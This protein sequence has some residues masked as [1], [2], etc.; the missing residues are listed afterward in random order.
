M[1]KPDQPINQKGW[2]VNHRNFYLKKFKKEQLTKLN[3]SERKEIINVRAG[4]LKWKTV[5][6]KISKIKIWFFEKHELE[7]ECP[8][9]C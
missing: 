2:R 1:A 7:P 8:Q 4:L 9:P 6:K 3:K 5:V